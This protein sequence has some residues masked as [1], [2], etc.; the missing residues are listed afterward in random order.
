MTLAKGSTAEVVWHELECGGYRRDLGLWRTLAEQHGDPVLEIGA[1]TGRVALT[2]ARAGYRVTALERDPALL[3]EL[4]RRARELPVRVAEADARH[5]ALEDRFA[6][7]IVAMQTI[8]LFGGSA[9]R[10]AFLA[11]ARR[12]LRDGGIVAVAIVEQLTLFRATGDGHE[13]PAEACDRDGVLYSSRPTAVLSDASGFLLERRREASSQTG[14][15]AVENESVRID[16]LTAAELESEAVSVGLHPAGRT[17]V[18]ATPE[19][20]GSTV[21]VLSA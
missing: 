18:P 11:S 16:R 3:A 1:G 6:L 9:G 2:L 5:F 13:L 21:V 17:S 20:T 8:Q 15:H 14:E 7:C 12:H 4:S 10:R 19:H